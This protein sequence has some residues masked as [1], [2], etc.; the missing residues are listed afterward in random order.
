MKTLTISKRVIASIK[1]CTGATEDDI[2]AVLAA[3]NYDVNE[4][5]EQLVAR[6]TCVLYAPIAGLHVGLAL[7]RTFYY[8]QKQARKTARGKCIKSKY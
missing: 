2:G 1:E 8:C 7:C 4:A 3:N 6:A 5:V